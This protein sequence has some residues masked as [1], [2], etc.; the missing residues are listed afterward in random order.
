M[1]TVR[2]DQRVA[3]LAGN[4][5]T[6]RGIDE[7]RRH[8]VIVLLD[9]G[10]TMAGPNGGCTQARLH[11]A[12]ETHEQAAAVDRVLR[13]AVAGIQ[14]ARLA[15]DRPAIRGVVRELPGLDCR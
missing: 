15:P 5:S 8:A 1:D 4:R 10:E 11:G 7:V 3:A 13:P 2:T 9:V 12:R 6:G 14:A